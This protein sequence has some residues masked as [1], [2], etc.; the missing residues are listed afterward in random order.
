M[1][2]PEL[3]KKA[4]DA[5]LLVETALGLSLLSMYDCSSVINNPEDRRTAT[6]APIVAIVPLLRRACDLLNDMA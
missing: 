6:D 5:F 4:A 2:K 3:E 1:D